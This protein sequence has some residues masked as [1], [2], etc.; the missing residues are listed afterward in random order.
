MGIP[1]LIS[2]H[3]SIIPNQ[4]CFQVSPSQDPSWPLKK[5]LNLI[6]K[7]TGRS[8]QLNPVIWRSPPK[9]HAFD[10]KTIYHQSICIKFQSKL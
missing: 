1:E 8:L 7:I 5:V 6:S 10:P 9:A 2:C 3:K 4:P